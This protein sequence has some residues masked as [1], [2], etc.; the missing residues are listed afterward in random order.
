MKFI[1]IVKILCKRYNLS[2]SD[3]IESAK[4]LKSDLMAFKTEEDIIKFLE[5]LEREALRATI[6]GKMI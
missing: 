5:S 4:Q 1:E 2:A 6:G 3:A